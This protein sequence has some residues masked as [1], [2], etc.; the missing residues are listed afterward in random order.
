M[1]TLQHHWLSQVTPGK[2]ATFI[3]TIFLKLS[4]ENKN[5][6][7]FGIAQGIENPFHVMILGVLDC[8]PL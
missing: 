1:S 2:N 4:N 7:D 3:R 8:N 6:R 5:M